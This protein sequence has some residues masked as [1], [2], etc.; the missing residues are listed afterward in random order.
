MLLHS[1]DFEMPRCTKVFNYET[2]INERR[3]LA[4]VQDLADTMKCWWMTAKGFILV[5]PSGSIQLGLNWPW[6][7]SNYSIRVQFE[8]LR[9]ALTVL[10]WL[11][12]SLYCQRRS[13]YVPYQL[14][15]QIFTST[16]NLSAYVYFGRSYVSYISNYSAHHIWQHALIC[17]TCA[18]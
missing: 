18:S 4:L 10:A 9:C 7:L 1:R 2:P 3:L 16:S 6:W 5:I 11:G 15:I 13:F 8:Q 14:V 17:Y 12:A